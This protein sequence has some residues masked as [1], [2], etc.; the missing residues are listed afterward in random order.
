MSLVEST[1]WFIFKCRLPSSAYKLLEEELDRIRLLA[2]I[3]PDD[4]LSQEARDGLCLELIVANS[5]NTPD[6][7][8]V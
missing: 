1:N 2:N 3:D 5:A 6:E 7:S 8:V 4:E